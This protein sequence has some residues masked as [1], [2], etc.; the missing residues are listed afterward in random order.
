MSALPQPID[1]DSLK[2]VETV[3]SVQGM[4]NYACAC[5]AVTECPSWGALCLAVQVSESLGYPPLTAWAREWAQIKDINSAEDEALFRVIMDQDPAMG[6]HLDSYTGHYIAA[7][8]AERCYMNGDMEM[9]QHALHRLAQ[10]PLAA[11]H[12]P[13]DTID[14]VTEWVLYDILYQ[15]KVTGIMQRDR[16][17]VALTTRS[18]LEKQRLLMDFSRLSQRLTIGYK[19]S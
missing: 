7:R 13:E 6:M 19:P 18:P 8:V 4:I 1:L 5:N 15:E 17:Q 12:R 16:L 3:S 9:M 10:V 2:T 14:P 11:P